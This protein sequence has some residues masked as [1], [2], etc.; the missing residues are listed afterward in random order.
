MTTKRTLMFAAAILTL[1]IFITV[2]MAGDDAEE[3]QKDIRKLM[4]IT[5]SGNIGVQVMNE[6][7]ASFKAAMPTVPDK[8]WSDFMAQT[9][10]EILVD[11]VVPV[12]DKYL[13]HQEIKELIAFY[14]TPLGKKLI[15]V[16]PMIVR[17]SM[18]IGRQWGEEMGNKVV[19][20]L[21]EQG[22]YDNNTG[23]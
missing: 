10:P 17:D 8:F 6:M 16:Q 15:S 1:F 3:K 5:G 23:Q 11:L 7:M 20:K 14:D 22:Y 4:E 9:K 21:R 2:A 12:Y 18:Q 13:T 19:Q